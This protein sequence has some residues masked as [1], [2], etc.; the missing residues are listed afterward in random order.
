MNGKRAKLYRA[1][2]RALTVGKPEK[3]YERNNQTGVVRLK[4]DCTRSVYK[5]FKRGR[6]KITSVQPREEQPTEQV[7]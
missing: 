6:L 1:A 2:A 7:S 3:A 5:D 4:R